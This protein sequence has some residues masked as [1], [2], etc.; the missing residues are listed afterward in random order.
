MRIF[1]KKSVSDRLKAEAI[2]LG[3]CNQWQSEWG[4]PTKDELC[5]KYI[6]GLDFCIKHDFPDLRFMKRHFNGV[7]QNHGIFVDNNEICLCNQGTVVANGHTTGQ[8]YY[9]GFSVG[10]VYVRHQSFIR[11]IARGNA[12]VNVRCYDTPKVEVACRDNARVTVIR[13]D[14]GHVSASGNVKVIN[15]NQ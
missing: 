10:Q 8:A 9:D 14:R 4:N 6:R 1:I 5:E 13:H 15:R 2:K 11:I 12:I 3:L 7:M